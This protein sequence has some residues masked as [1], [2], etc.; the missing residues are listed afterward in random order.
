[1]TGDAEY[2]SDSPH[3]A[4]YE[5]IV[6]RTEADP[7]GEQNAHGNL[8]TS[9]ERMRADAVK[10]HTEYTKESL[11]DA[12]GHL[13]E[14]GKVVTWFGLLAPATDE[15]LQAIIENEVNS[16]VTRTILVGQCNELRGGA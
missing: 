6:E 4:V 12:L 13:E 1:M 11:N 7:D 15:H 9:T 5:Q 16:G 14:N 10:P 2:E 3:G 8:W